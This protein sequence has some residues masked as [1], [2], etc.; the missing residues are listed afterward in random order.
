MRCE[1]PHALLALVLVSCTVSS[2]GCGAHE[3]NAEGAGGSPVTDA[4][5]DVV[6][7]VEA[8]VD[9]GP[10]A[11]AAPNAPAP[12]LER[13]CTHPWQDDLTPAKVGELGGTYLGAYQELPIGTLMTMKVIPEHPFQVTK[14]RVAFAGDAGPI[15]LRLMHTFGRSYPDLD[16]P[17]GDLIPPVELDIP[18]PD[19]EQWIEID[20]SEHGLF[21][22][23][24][25]HYA[26]V[27]EQLAANPLLAVEDLPEGEPSRALMLVPGESV[28]YGSEGNF[29]MELE[30]NTFC[31]WSDADRWFSADDTQPFS[32]DSSP[33]VAVADLNGDGHDDVVVNAGGPLAYFGDGNGGFV[34]PS[35]DPFPD[36]LG[37]SMLVF[38]DIDNDGDLDAFANYY[39]SA[40]GDGDGVTI[41]EGDCND[42]DETVR[43]ST[44][45][46]PG[47][48]LDDDCD[49]TADDGTAT[50]DTDQDNVTIADGDCD[51][52][53]DDVFPGAP[54][55]L[56]ARDNDCDLQVD[57]DFANRILL[58]DGQAHF[59]VMDSAGVEVLDPSTA[60]AFGDANGDGNLDLYWGNWL[61]H[62]PDDP[63]VQDR[64]FEGVGDGT[65]VDAQQASGLVLP[66]A[67]S[68]Y[69][70]M[71]NDYDNDGFQDIFVG[72]Y[73]LYANQLWRNQGDGTFLDV[74]TTVGAAYDDIPSPYAYLPGGHTYGGD[75]ADVDNDGDM[76]MYMANLAH[77]RTQ[78]WG[79]P[80]M[81]LVNDGPPSFT[82]QN[83]RAEVG[84]V[85]D[86]GDV[87]AAFADFDND[88]DVDLAVA[89]LYTTH[90]SRLY[91][92]DGGQ[93]TDVTYETNTAVHDAVSVVW[94]DV[95]ED[96]D[97]DLLIADRDGAPNV[98]LFLN[99]VG[100][101]NHWVELVLEG[102]ST[103]RGAV[104]ARVSLRAGGVTQ[105]REVKGGGGHSNTQSTSV[106][107]FGLAKESVIDEVTVRWV[108]GATE[109]ISGLAPNGR[110]R[111]V[112]GSGKGVVSPG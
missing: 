80:S 67:F 5:A 83:R 47:N 56:D 19:P 55:L 88:M 22:L 61:L 7:D 13:F 46:K 14:V 38:G 44:T 2:V 41:D 77:P 68:C 18:D 75:F 94:S 84:F 37:A 32:Q 16:S 49:G 54:E 59:T 101:D 20:V 34:K 105:L 100:Q 53:R 104:G 40:D 95:D 93:F 110:Y 82:F 108:G 86:E 62:Y 79:D 112:E 78:P 50:A 70:V 11:D 71:W 69:G 51:D 35:F 3:P 66:K 6:A 107:H 65:F 48:G 106:I 85:Y 36:A 24:T 17:E 58:N 9:A 76:D 72:N 28:P 23:P 29:R 33:R 103:N 99:R 8:G 45:E 98:V 87:N 60:A 39:V 10:E 27:S 96:G 109:T 30:G 42:A 89:S 12:E 21:L 26:I 57:E 81:F 73:H 74:A 52:N 91:R 97:Q 25:Q 15:R 63:A 64:Y 1:L 31:A 4:A 43:P 90:Y 102:V 111:V 92:N